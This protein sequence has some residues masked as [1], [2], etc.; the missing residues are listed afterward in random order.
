MGAIIPKEVRESDLSHRISPNQG[1]L[2]IIGPYQ[3]NK[4]VTR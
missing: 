1:G 4:E 3:V 2:G